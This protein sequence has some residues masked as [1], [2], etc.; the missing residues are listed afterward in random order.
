MAN[1]NV[2]RRVRNERGVLVLVHCD[3]ED[4]VRPSV[5]GALG[6][7]RLGSNFC[8]CVA[9]DSTIRRPRKRFRY[10]CESPRF[11]R[12]TSDWVLC[13]ECV[14]LVQKRFINAKW[15]GWEMA[16]QRLDPI[17]LDE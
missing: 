17:S 1:I 14:V 11:E 12:Q 8:R 7:G 9:E 16:K 10:S 4:T 3:E 13:R 15:M 6:N 2:V 5:R